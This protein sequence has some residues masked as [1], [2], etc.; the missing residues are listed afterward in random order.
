VMRFTHPLQWPSYF[1]S[2]HASDDGPDGEEDISCPDHMD[3]QPRF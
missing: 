1:E 2:G 3:K